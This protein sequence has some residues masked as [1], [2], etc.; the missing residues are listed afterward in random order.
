MSEKEQGLSL[1]EQKSMGIEGKMKKN[2]F[3]TDDMKQEGFA[4]L[5]CFESQTKDYSVK[6]QR[7][8]FYI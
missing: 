8:T 3:D 4:H 6:N 1:D 7:H 5:R 2:N